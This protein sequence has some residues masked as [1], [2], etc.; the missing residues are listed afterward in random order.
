MGIMAGNPNEMKQAALAG[1]E[2]AVGALFVWAGAVK[3]L[4]PAHF[5][6]DIQNYRL[7][8][9][10]IGVGA[11]LYLPWLEMA[12]GTAMLV[13]RGSRG[14]LWLVTVMMLVFI[15]ALLSAQIRGLDVS[16]GCF[17]R[18]DAPG[19]ATALVRD[20]VILAALAVLLFAGQGGGV[21]GL[22]AGFR[23]GG[24]PGASG[25]DF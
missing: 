3:A 23:A 2:I 19:V 10:T 25:R 22:I 5:A 20:L 6:L 18:A 9:W 1:L 15:G 21:R 14:A 11:A 4:D 8:P 13:G 17:G 16:C 7:V 12:C 24:A